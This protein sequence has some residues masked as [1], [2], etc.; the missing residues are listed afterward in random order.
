MF[1][2]LRNFGREPNMW[3]IVFKAF[4]FPGMYM[5]QLKGNAGYTSVW[6]INI[7]SMC[8]YAFATGCLLNGLWLIACVWVLLAIWTMLLYMD[9]WFM[10]VSRQMFER[11]RD[12]LDPITGEKINVVHQTKSPVE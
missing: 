12:G 6:I 8:C 2:F 7:V 5:S 4:F 10:L 3:R 11:Q 1:W 9:S